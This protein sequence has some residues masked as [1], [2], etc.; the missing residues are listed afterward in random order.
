MLFNGFSYM[1]T[2]TK[3]MDLFEQSEVNFTKF[4]DTELSKQRGL[5]LNLTIL[6]TFNDWPE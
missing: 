6:A 1:S 4:L 5:L 3:P 2:V